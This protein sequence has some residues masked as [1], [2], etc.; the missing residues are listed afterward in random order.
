MEVEA[1]AFDHSDLSGHDQINDQI[2]DQI[3]EPVNTDLEDKLLSLLKQKP[4]ITMPEMAEALGVSE[5]T[6]QRSLDLLRDDK[7]VV[8]EGSRKAGFWRVVE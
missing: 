1:D 4:T 8:R 7:R 5:K 2:N 6:I 3:K